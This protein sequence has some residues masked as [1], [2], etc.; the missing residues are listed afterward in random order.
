[1][2]KQHLFVPPA[3]SHPQWGF[4]LTFHP[5]SQG[6]FVLSFLVWLRGFVCFFLHPKN[7]PSKLGDWKTLGARVFCGNSMQFVL[8]H[9]AGWF[10]GT[11]EV[12][13]NIVCSRFCFE[14]L[15]SLPR[16]RTAKLYLISHIL[17]LLPCSTQGLLVLLSAKHRHFKVNRLSWNLFL[18]TKSPVSPGPYFVGPLDLEGSE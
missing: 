11:S 9:H 15:I 3:V 14:V 7:A 10:T 16:G 6:I 12:Q 1:M 17:R 18:D 4:Q 5:R 2:K 8:K 13:D